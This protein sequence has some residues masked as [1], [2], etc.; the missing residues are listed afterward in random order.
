MFK[1]DFSGT[2]SGISIIIFAFARPIIEEGYSLYNIN[3][4]Y[5]EVEQSRINLVENREGCNSAGEW[6]SMKSM[7]KCANKSTEIDNEYLLSKKSA[8]P[9]GS[10]NKF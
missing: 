6:C 10:G 7:K 5:L 1:C 4:P 8:V 9:E 2:T 3:L